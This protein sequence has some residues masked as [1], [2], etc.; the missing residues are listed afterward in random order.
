MNIIEDTMSLQV[1]ELTITLGNVSYMVFGLFITL[2]LGI[3]V[4]C[5]YSRKDVLQR[6]YQLS[7]IP[8]T[9]ML[10]YANGVPKMVTAIAHVVTLLIAIS[11]GWRL[12]YIK[13]KSD[14]IIL[15]I[16]YAVFI[17]LNLCIFQ[18]LSDYTHNYFMNAIVTIQK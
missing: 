10:Y 17:I 14:R 15:M 5:V 9:I 2:I 6:N 3:I 7:F 18:K 1:K 12:D 4:F 11:L 16:I 8:M 13:S